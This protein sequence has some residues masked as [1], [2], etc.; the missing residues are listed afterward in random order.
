MS[1]DKSGEKD[2][3]ILYKSEIFKDGPAAGGNYASSIGAEQGIEVFGGGQAPRKRKRPAKTHLEAAREIPVFAETDVLVVGGG[4]AGTAAAISAARLGADVLLVERYNHLGGLSTGGLVIW[5]DR[6][7]DWSGKQIICGFASDIMDRLPKDAV[8]GPQQTDWGSK[9]AATAAY[10]AQRT[11]AFHGIVT[12]SPTVD[13]EALKTASMQMVS[14]AKVRLLLHAWAAAPILD[15]ST[16]KGAIFESK[17]G[18]HAVLAKVVIDTTGDAD[19]IAR[20]HAALESDIDEGDIHHCINT[21]FLIGGVDMERWLAFRKNEPEAF[22]AF[23]A[24]GRAKLKF[25]EKPF[26][27]WRNDIALFMGPRLSGYSAV[28]VEDLTAVELRSRHL[29]VGHLD[30]YRSLAPGFANA[31]LMLGAPQVGVRHS[32]RLS[33]VRKVTRRQWDTGQVW[34]DEIGVS[35]SLSPKFANI[36]VPYGALIP[37]ELDNILGA[38]RHVA[39]D[40]SSHT[41]LREIPQCWLTGQAAGV[42]AA[43]AVAQGKRPRDVDATVIQRELLRQGAY[44]SPAIERQVRPATAA[45]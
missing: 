15:G 35:A 40:A 43:L 28:D 9:D 14:E 41:F 25:F 23:M 10:W 27:S 26:V 21:A 30:V 2:G 44:L 31:F 45:E 20:T 18:R 4:P 5:I 33:G 17:E 12:W 7:S 3:R 24:E 13:P 1:D 32:R 19:L 8:Q 22:S 16:V 37:A 34:D 29:A 39:C 42:A 38:G 36:S 11:S 6:M